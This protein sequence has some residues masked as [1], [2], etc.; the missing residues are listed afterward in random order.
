MFHVQFRIRE[1]EVK[2]NHSVARLC[3]WITTVNNRSSGKP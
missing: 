3:L 1:G 2:K